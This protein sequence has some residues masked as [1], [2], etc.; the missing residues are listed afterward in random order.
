MFLVK[1]TAELVLQGFVVGP[2]P[3]HVLVFPG[4]VMV[5]DSNFMTPKLP[6]LQ[7]EEKKLL[8]IDAG[9]FEIYFQ[10]K[11]CLTFIF[12]GKF[13]KVL[14]SNKNLLKLYFKMK[15]RFY[16]KCI[17]IKNLLKNCF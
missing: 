2:Q 14:F 4:A 10:T 16:W 8:K 7:F 5:A 13:L 1:V 17:F 15:I 3:G 9:L 6:N 11:I 12:V